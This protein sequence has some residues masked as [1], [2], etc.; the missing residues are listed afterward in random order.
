MPTKSEIIQDL[1]WVTERISNR[2]WTVSVGVIALALTYIVESTRSDGSP[3]LRPEQVA[4]PAV[5]ALLALA[6]DLI[7]YIAA[8]RQ[9]VRILRR[10]E[11]EGLSEARFD[12][13]ERMGRLR[14][15]A[16]NL[17]ISLSILSVGWIASVT[18][19]R[20]LVVIGWVPL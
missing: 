16:Y 20:T 6:F 19:G 9:N 14:H 15:L 1:N 5:L 4:V 3:F 11:R 10:M 13:A 17:K 18:I 2:V 12:P 8:N 7:Q